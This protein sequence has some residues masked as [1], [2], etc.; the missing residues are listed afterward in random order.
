M[1]IVQTLLLHQH[2][3]SPVLHQHQSSPVLH[4]HQSSPTAEDSDGRSSPQEIRRAL[5]PAAVVDEALSLA[6]R[7][8]QC[9]SHSRAA[10]LP[11][12]GSA[13]HSRCL[14]LVLTVVRWASCKI[15]EGI[16]GS[17]ALSQRVVNQH[18]IS[19]VVL[20]DSAM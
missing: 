7:L 11:S 17:W 10:E 9:Q 16:G 1:Q 19:G 15:E 3:S 20:G 12:S 13:L 18:N 14:G 6:L 4:Q 5:L 2:K 8:L